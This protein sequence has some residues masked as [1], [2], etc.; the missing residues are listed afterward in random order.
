MWH[1]PAL[2]QGKILFFIYL[3]KKIEQ[4]GKKLIKYEFSDYFQSLDKLCSQANERDNHL[5]LLIKIVEWPYF[6]SLARMFLLGQ[7]WW[8]LVMNIGCIHTW[9]F[10]TDVIISD[11]RVPKISSQNIL[12]AR[13]SMPC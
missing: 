6:S 9:L 11:Y 3:S 5:F 7:F 10:R 1:S 2:Y 8:F 13:L 12:S 4:P